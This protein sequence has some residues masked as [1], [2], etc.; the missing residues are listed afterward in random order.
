MPKCHAK[1]FKDI[2]QIFKKLVGS[3]KAHPDCISET[4]GIKPLNSFEIAGIGQAS[5]VRLTRPEL[6]FKAVSIFFRKMLY[7]FWETLE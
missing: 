1:A 3:N 7:D 4:K 5:S 6:G 2:K